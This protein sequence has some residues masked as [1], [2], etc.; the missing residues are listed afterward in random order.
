MRLLSRI[1][2]L[3][4]V[5]GLAVGLVLRFR[6]SLKHLPTVYALGALP[7]LGHLAYVAF[8]TLENG[9]NLGGPLALFA[10]SSLLLGSLWLFAGWRFLRKSPSRLALTPLGLVLLHGLPLLLYSQ[11]LRNASI[12]MDA[13]PV[14]ALVCAALFV[15]SLQFAFG[16]GRSPAPR[17]GLLARWRR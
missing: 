2:I 1:A 13:I 16:F 9:S 8:Y 10:G 3:W 7:W 5:L 17:R 12:G 6:L 4:I 11:V 15:A 14:V